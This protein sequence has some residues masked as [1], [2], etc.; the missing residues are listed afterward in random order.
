[1]P[2][3]TPSQDRVINFAG[4]R[5]LDAS[6][7]NELQALDLAANNGQILGALYAVGGT[8]NLT[9]QVSGTDVLLSPTNSSAP[10]QVFIRGCWE[11]V[12]PAALSYDPGKTVGTDYVF[13][14]YT[15]WRVTL[16]TPGTIQDSS[17]QDALTSEPIG[18]VGQLE[19]AFS[20]TD[21]STTPLNPVTQLETNTVP[22]VIATLPRGMGATPAISVVIPD[23]ALPAAL[24][25]TNRSGL[26]RLS[27][28]DGG[29]ALAA[30]DPILFTPPQISS[31]NVV[32]LQ[33]SSPPSS[34]SL[35]LSTWS[36]DDAHGIH[37]NLILHEATGNHLEDLSAWLITGVRSLQAQ[38]ASLQSGLSTLAR[39][40]SNLNTG[41]G[42]SG[43]NYAPASH[44]G[45]PLGLSTSHPSA[46]ISDTSGWSVQRDVVGG[47]SAANQAFGL[48]DLESTTLF[49]VGHDGSVYSQPGDSFLANGT[50]L[51][52]YTALA[53]ALAT[54]VANP[55]VTQSYVDS[56]EATGNAATLASAKTYTD[57]VTSTAP[58]VVITNNSGGS[59]AT[60]T[61]FS[62]GSV[63]L[64]FL[65][66]Q[67]A[68][69]VTLI[70]PSGFDSARFLG[71]ASA[72]TMFGLGS[73]WGTGH[74]IQAQQAVFGFQAGTLTVSAHCCDDSTPPNVTGVGWASVL[75]VAW[76]FAG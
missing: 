64:A 26:L 4:G 37:A 57:L 13:L 28:G 48:T 63:T 75:G 60:W 54:L 68:D 56:T 12:P 27:Y 9:I 8:A 3:R 53:S 16:N 58:T 72:S 62:I 70:L 73:G 69:G 11:A 24:G 67:L 61:I 18:D 2:P 1:M 74:N 23:R 17:L 49:S 7:L 47:G 66:G 34:S 6:E 76:T 40:V 39:I 59:V 25:D 10:I 55:G 42:P 41:A 51:G 35:G 21:T 31:S 19:V 38:A 15:V 33:A 14:N 29:V 20:A 22:I 50:P 45:L 65:S 46:I 71:Q 32:P 5:I 52:S 44:V 36:D 43:T 30:D